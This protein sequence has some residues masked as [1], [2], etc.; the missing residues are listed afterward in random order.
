MDGTASQEKIHE[1][2]E[3]SQAAIARFARM[4]AEYRQMQ[5]D[6]P[7][8]PARQRIDDLIKLNDDT[9]ALLHRG[10]LITEGDLSRAQRQGTSSG[11]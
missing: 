4:S 1:R 8:G 6:L 11:L 9:A 3:K 2:I 7:V 10:L 5:K